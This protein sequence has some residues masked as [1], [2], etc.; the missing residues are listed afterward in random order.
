MSK[1]SDTLE[2][3]LPTYHSSSANPDTKVQSRIVPEM[4]DSFFCVG[5]LVEWWCS[6]SGKA[7]D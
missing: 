1:L 5:G 6:G 7:L 2:L 4:N 3:M